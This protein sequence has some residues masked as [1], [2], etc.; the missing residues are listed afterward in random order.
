M[1]LIKWFTY[2]DISIAV[3]KNESSYKCIKYLDGDKLVGESI[4]FKHLKDLE[5]YLLE[6]PGCP[7]TEVLNFIESHKQELGNSFENLD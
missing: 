4:Q 1:E 7:R 6:H 5:L 2:F 3:Q